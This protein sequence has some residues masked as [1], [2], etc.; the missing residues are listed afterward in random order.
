MNYLSVKHHYYL[1]GLLQLSLCKNTHNILT[2]ACFHIQM[3]TLGD[4][5]K[6][7]VYINDISLSK[8]YMAQLHY[9]SGLIM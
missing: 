8:D 1:P 9:P 5:G 4:V 2:A 7:L 3:K 6:A